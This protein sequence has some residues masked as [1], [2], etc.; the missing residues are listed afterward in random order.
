MPATMSAIPRHV[1]AYRCSSRSSGSRSSRVSNP[2]AARV[3]DSIPAEVSDLGRAAEPPIV[4]IPT[5][6]ERFEHQEAEDLVDRL[7]EDVRELVGLRLAGANWTEVASKVGWRQADVVARVR[8]AV[9]RA[10]GR[11]L[12]DPSRA[13]TR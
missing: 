12:D 2:S 3:V 6:A 1:S 5:P 9:G 7:P 13:S 11:D 4:Y 10:L 8:A